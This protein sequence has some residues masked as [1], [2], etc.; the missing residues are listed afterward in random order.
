MSG[1][2]K[3]TGSKSIHMRHNRNLQPVQQLYGAIG[4]NAKMANMA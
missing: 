3:D 4:P 1:L 2:G